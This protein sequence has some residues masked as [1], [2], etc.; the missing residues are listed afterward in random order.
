MLM[1]VQQHKIHLY[2]VARRCSAVYKQEQ[3]RDTIPHDAQPC[4]YCLGFWPGTD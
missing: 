2:P 4:P 3:L 1:F